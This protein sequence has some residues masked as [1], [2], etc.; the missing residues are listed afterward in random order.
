MKQHIAAFAAC[1]LASCV[2]CAAPSDEVICVDGVCR[3]AREVKAAYAALPGIHCQADFEQLVRQAD[4]PVLVGFYMDRC[5]PCRRF[6]PT[7]VLLAEEY[8]GRV[9]VIRAKKEDCPR[10]IKQC[11][12]TGYPTAVLYDEGQEVERWLGR[13]PADKYRGSLDAAAPDCTAWQP[14]DIP[15]LSGAE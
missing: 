4:R 3:P 11:N 6:M 15:R 13:W 8:H 14:R 5:E 7:V 10:V 12:V 1:A 2:G 9:D